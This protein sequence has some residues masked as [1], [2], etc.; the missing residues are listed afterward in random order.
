MF[1]SLLLEFFTQILQS[2]ITIVFFLLLSS[3]IVE[4]LAFQA[5][6][7]LSFLVLPA[8]V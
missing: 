2:K 1:V 3:A 6:P 5:G 8:E 4:F 7:A